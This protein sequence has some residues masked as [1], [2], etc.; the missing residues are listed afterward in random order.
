MLNKKISNDTETKKF[1]LRF[2][3]LMQ[4]GDVI[5][6]AAPTISS[7]GIRKVTRSNFSH[8][9]LYLGNSYMHSDLDGVHSGN[10]QRL[11]FANPQ[12]VKVLRLKQEHLNTQTIENICAFVRSEHGKQYSKFEAAKSVLTPNALNQK[13]RQFCSRLVAQSF[14]NAG[15]KIVQNSNYCTPH[16]I[17]ISDYFEEIHDVTKLANDE[18]IEFENSKNPLT[19][20]TEITNNLLKNIRALIGQ[21]IQTPNEIDNILIRNPEYDFQITDILKKSGY[22]EIWKIDYEKNPWKYDGSIFLTFNNQKQLVKFRKEI[23]NHSLDYNDLRIAMAYG[24]LSLFSGRTPSVNEGLRY[25]HQ[26]DL[27]SYLFSKHNLDY[28]Y[29]QIKLYE[30]L[31]ENCRKRI[32]AAKHVLRHYGEID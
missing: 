1:I 27:Y 24:E 11:L 14:E 16:E 26:Y 23:G 5:L 8:A 12:D 9:I 4:P 10:P 32:D 18:E 7:K 21:D 28:F 13:N 15:I 20:Q 19:Y 30:Q 22:L 6:T 17:S 25:Q 29:T 31:L 2:A 3:E